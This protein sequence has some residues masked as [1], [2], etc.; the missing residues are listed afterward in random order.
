MALAEMSRKASNDAVGARNMNDRKASVAGR[1]TAFDTAFLLIESPRT[2]MHMGFVG[3]FEG[4]PLR[5][6]GQVRV[7]E[8]RCEIE[9][10]LPLAPRLTQRVVWGA[11]PWRIPRWEDDPSFQLEAH[12]R[13]VALPSPG[14]E[15]TLLELCGALLAES[16]D[17]TRPLWEIWIVD[18]LADGKV[19]LVG[20]VHHALADGL[21]GVD[22][23]TMLLAGL[24]DAG[25]SSQG[26]S[27]SPDRRAVRA[28]ANLW[29][30]FGTL[31]KGASP[32]HP[33]R[34]TYRLGT[35]LTGVTRGVLTLASPR[36]LAPRS[37]LNGPVGSE[38]RIA[39]V[40]HPLEPLRKV[41]RTFH[42]TLN[43]VL[44]AAVALGMRELIAGRGEKTTGREV[45]VAVPVALGRDTPR[46]LGN[47][48]SV[49]MVR[50]PLGFE[51]PLDVLG[52]VGSEVA[53]KKRH[54]QV[55]AG[56]WAIGLLDLVP[57]PVLEALVPTLNHQV[58][59]NTI[60]T[61]VPGPSRPLSLLGSRMLA[62]YPFVPLG[63]N[64]TLEVAALSYDGGF[65]LG[66]LADKRRCPD[67]D[68]FAEGV[69]RG[70]ARLE[71]LATPG[72]PPRRARGTVRG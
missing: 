42:V 45:Q 35:T 13:V 11:Q 50:L 26:S 1:L 48:L 62:A 3:I 72:E 71:A 8:I 15:E 19:V 6:D 9:R 7:E 17:R 16:L 28:R 33:M 54:H 58:V 27:W 34:N 20:K 29:E 21:A 43:D 61:D 66:I 69:R 68:V 10:R 32:W 25:K 49:L 18:G 22:L 70:L 47:Q 44:L 14:D 59:I 23:V 36:T 60:V 12:L 52:A 64:L 40:R 31:W 65:H 56:Q 39:V 41:G 55:L 53:G 30:L 57:T 67:L 24:P 5:R 2:P 37:S 4:E 38:R 63:G 46:R 51:D